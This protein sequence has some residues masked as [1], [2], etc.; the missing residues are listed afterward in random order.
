MTTESAYRPGKNYVFFTRALEILK[1]EYIKDNPD[2]EMISKIQENMLKS[3]A[4]KGSTFLANKAVNV[5]IELWAFD[6]EKAV[7]EGAIEKFFERDQS[8]FDTFLDTLFRKNE[9]FYELDIL[10]KEDGTGFITID[11]YSFKYREGVWKAILE[12]IKSDLDSLLKNGYGEKRSATEVLLAFQ[13]LSDRAK[14][15]DTAEARKLQIE[16]LNLT[17]ANPSYRMFVTTQLDRLADVI[18]GRFAI[19]PTD[20]NRNPF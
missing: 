1:A 11:V 16:L 20:T 13:S 18:S 2:L 3:E 8:P 15:G 9:M 4:F 17:E 12:N 5:Q 10:E 6:R 7:Q 14:N 19:F